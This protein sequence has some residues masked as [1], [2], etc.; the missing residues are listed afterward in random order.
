MHPSTST[1]SSFQKCTTEA[2]AY[3][4]SISVT[5]ELSEPPFPVNSKLSP[6]SVFHH[7]GQGQIDICGSALEMIVSP[8][9]PVSQSKHNCNQKILEG[10]PQ[11]PSER[12]LN[13]SANHTLDPLPGSVPT[14]AWL[15]PNPDSTGA[16]QITVSP[17]PSAPVDLS[18][19]DWNSIPNPLLETTTSMS[20]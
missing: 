19:F 9:P 5:S 17:S 16:S 14:F 11:V 18:V 7:T 15:A 20:R 6:G 10:S 12:Q 2:L 8:D 1:D 4:S 13:L 3:T